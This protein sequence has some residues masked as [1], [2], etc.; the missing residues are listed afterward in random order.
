MVHN[1]TKKCLVCQ[2]GLAVYVGSIVTHH[3]PPQSLLGLLAIRGRDTEGGLGMKSA[4]PSRI[5]QP[6]WKSQPEKNNPDHLDSVLELEDLHLKE[7][8]HFMVNDEIF[9]K[10]RGRYPS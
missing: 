3:I 4:T 1:D 2:R 5:S 7:I 9:R 6:C 10:P 8:C